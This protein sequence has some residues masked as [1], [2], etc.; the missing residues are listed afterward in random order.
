MLFLRLF[1]NKLGSIFARRLTLLVQT[2]N[3]GSTVALDIEIQSVLCASHILLTT[4]DIGDLFQ[5]L[6]GPTMFTI[7]SESLDKLED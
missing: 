2:L 3:C 5:L 6:R 1:G 4:A 7:V